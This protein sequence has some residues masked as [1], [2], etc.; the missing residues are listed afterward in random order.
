[1]IVEAKLV[2]MGF[3]RSTSPVTGGIP[4]I[5]IGALFGQLP[6]I[7]FGL[8]LFPASSFLANDKKSGVWRTDKRLP[9][10]AS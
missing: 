4:L 2:R 9:L 3:A 8:T 10:L 5:P 1:M 6:K 7:L